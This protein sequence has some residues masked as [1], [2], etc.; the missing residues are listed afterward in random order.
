MTRSLILA[1]LSDVHLTPLGAVPMRYWNAKR[2]LGYLNWRTRRRSTYERGAADRLV[3]DARANGAE[4]VVVTGDLVNLGLP[5][6]YEAARDWLCAL[7]P[8]DGVS[9]VP[10]NHDIYTA[11]NH[12]ASCLDAWGDY[13]A[14][15]SWGRAHAGED[16]FP[17]VRRVGPAV[18]VGVNSAVAQGP[19]VAAGRVG[20][21][22][23]DQLERVLGR[24]ELRELFRIVL[25]HHP[26][27]PGQA[28]ARR[29]LEDAA[30]L[31]H[32]LR[33]TGADLV[34]HGH[35]HRDMLAWTEGASGPIPVVGVASGSNVRRH[36]SGGLAQYKL[37]ALERAGERATI[38]MTTRGLSKPGGPVVE[39]SSQVL[40][41]RG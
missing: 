28:P 6:E 5:S 27:L 38:R 15:C 13:M 18:L 25:I 9:L 2:A 7:G 22:Q 24:S 30:P 26:P 11:R 4:H 8:A 1:H 20:A 40:L 31:A 3:E 37:F 39:L 35:N 12:G 34:L 33:R 41:P 23:L 29:G 16:T 32:V 21:A 19:F 17:Y 36:G 14:S 10:G